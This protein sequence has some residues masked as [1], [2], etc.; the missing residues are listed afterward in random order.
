MIKENKKL[1]E[2]TFVEL[3]MRQKKYTTVV[4]ILSIF[5]M[6]TLALLIYFAIKSNNYTFLMLCGGSS[7]ALL[8]CAVILKKVESEI[9]A[10]EIE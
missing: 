5:T 10:R 8:L 9:M 7:F 3:K 4:S 6:L 1:K 2:L